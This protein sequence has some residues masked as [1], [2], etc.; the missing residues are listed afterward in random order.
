[1]VI[2]MMVIINIMVTITSIIMMM[3]VRMVMNIIMMM[4][5]ERRF[6]DGCTPALRMLIPNQHTKRSAAG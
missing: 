5:G 1:M 3:I 4:L 6:R 2:I